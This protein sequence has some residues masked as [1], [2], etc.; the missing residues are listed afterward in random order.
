MASGPKERTGVLVIRVWM[1]H[2][3]E[4]RARITHT[5]DVNSTRELTT[6]AFSSTE[7]S[8]TV[9]AWL[10]GFTAEESADPPAQGGGG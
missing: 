6:T 9:I 8:A 10:D 1:E 4:I 7:I 2:P 5:L 3:S